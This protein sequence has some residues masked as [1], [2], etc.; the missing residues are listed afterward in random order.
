[1]AGLIRRHGGSKKTRPPIAP[2]AQLD[3]ASG[4]EPGGRRFESC[5]A[6]HFFLKTLTASGAWRGHGIRSAL[7]AWLIDVPHTMI[8]RK[9]PR[10]RAEDGCSP[11]RRRGANCHSRFVGEPNQFIALGSPWAEAA[12]V[13]LDL[14]ARAVAVPPAV[15]CLAPKASDVVPAWSSRRARGSTAWGRLVRAGSE[16]HQS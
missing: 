10:R 4:Y 14:M 8:V 2:L 13:R 11:P 16:R 5:R 3:R 15:H 6:R 9:N 12:P 7:L 1:V